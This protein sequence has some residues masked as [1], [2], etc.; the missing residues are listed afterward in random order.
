MEVDGAMPPS[1]P[2]NF[3]LRRYPAGIS[4]RHLFV[5]RGHYSLAFIQSS[6]FVD[7]HVS[8]LTGAVKE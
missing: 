6:F 4:S 7:Y 3:K 5:E 8:S 2:A 1:R